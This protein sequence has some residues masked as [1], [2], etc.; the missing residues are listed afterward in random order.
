MRNLLRNRK[1][2]IRL[3][4]ITLLVCVSLLA[5]Y[6][7]MAV[8]APHHLQRIGAIWRSKL[9]PGKPG[10]IILAAAEKGGHYYRLGV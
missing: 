10:S 7:L 2:N 6:L 5:V 1:R 4:K 8:F 9:A 3:L